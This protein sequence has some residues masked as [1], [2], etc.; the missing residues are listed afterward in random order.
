ML[1]IAKEIFNVSHNDFTVISKYLKGVIVPCWK[2]VDYCKRN[3]LT[4]S[5][6]LIIV[7]NYLKI[8]IKARS[9]N[10][11]FLKR[12]LKSYSHDVIAIY[13]CLKSAIIPRW[14]KNYS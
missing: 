8:E 2:N 9:K 10:V 6:R 14:K 7:Y 4:S 12:N 5:Y 11:N 13:N 3:L 1:I